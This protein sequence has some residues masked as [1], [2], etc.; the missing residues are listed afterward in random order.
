[1]GAQG[2]G[3]EIAVVAVLVAIAFVVLLFFL[4]HYLQAGL[5]VLFLKVCRGEDARMGDLFSGGGNFW[6]YLGTSLLFGLMVAIGMILC[7]VP[8]YLA[9]IVFGPCLYLSI[10]RRVGVIEALRLSSQLTKGRRMDIFI[11]L[12]VMYGIAM[13]GGMVPCGQL[14]VMPFITLAMTVMYLRLTGQHVV[15]A[16][17]KKPRPIPQAATPA[18]P[19]TPA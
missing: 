16:P 17:P 3:P 12:L 19:T 11:V 8:G 13:L 14:F 6:C 2:A 4:I 15:P 18:A 10:D 5:T 7:I 9:M 1:L